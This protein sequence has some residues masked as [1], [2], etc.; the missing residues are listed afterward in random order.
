MYT[1]ICMLMNLLKT[2]DNISSPL[3][4]FTTLQSI[5]SSSFIKDMLHTVVLR[6]C[7]LFFLALV[8][9]ISKKKRY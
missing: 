8:E 6:S 7:Y 1:I 2:V 3:F 9:E 4:F 5:C